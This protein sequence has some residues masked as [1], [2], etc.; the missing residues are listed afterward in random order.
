MIAF[1]AACIINI[2][3]SSSYYYCQIKKLENK[4]LNLDTFGTSV[5]RNQSRVPE[6]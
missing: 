1:A 6:S 2:D 5:P 3:W 4:I